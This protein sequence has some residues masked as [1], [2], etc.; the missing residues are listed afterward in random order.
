M[1]FWR[2]FA[3]FC[4]GNPDFLPDLIVSGHQ[5]FILLITVLLP[6]SYHWAFS[7][8]STPPIQGPSHFLVLWSMGVYSLP[9]RSSGLPFPEI[10]WV[11]N[12]TSGSNRSKNSLVLRLPRVA[13]GNSSD[14]LFSTNG[15]HSL[16]HT[17][18]MVAKPL[19]CFLDWLLICKNP[20][21]QLWPI[22][23]SW[24]YTSIPLCPVEW[25]DDDHMNG[26]DR[27]EALGSWS[28]DCEY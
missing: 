2:S 21:T 16:A 4:L 20:A 9:K 14:W 10:I 1:F 18:E 26:M 15:R 7:L 17:M 28:F 12:P 27:I 24:T 23:F 19:S 6:I 11:T 25:R 3:V 5:V 22:S 8:T 13:E